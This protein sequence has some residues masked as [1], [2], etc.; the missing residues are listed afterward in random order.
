MNQS[1]LVRKQH[2]HGPKGF[3]KGTTTTK[4]F[5]K[6]KDKEIPDSGFRIPDSGFRIP[7]LVKEEETQTR[8]GGF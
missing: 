8:R 6:D 1:R 2:G 4:I 5:D 7:G 3:P